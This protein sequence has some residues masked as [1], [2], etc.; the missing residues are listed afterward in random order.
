MVGPN[1]TTGHGQMGQPADQRRYNAK[2]ASRPLLTQAVTT[3]IL[4]ATGDITAQQ[5]V[6]RRGLDKHDFVRTGRMALYGGGEYSTRSTA[7]A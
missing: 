1:G 6:D 4:F 7:T 2:L 5:V 3:S